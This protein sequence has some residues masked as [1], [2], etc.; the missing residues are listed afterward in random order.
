MRL[1]SPFRFDNNPGESNICPLSGEDLFRFESLEL[2]APIG[3][4]EPPSTLRS[5]ELSTFNRTILGFGQ[6]RV[7]QGE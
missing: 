6:D 1:G 7:E 4:C 3:S 2:K 5:D